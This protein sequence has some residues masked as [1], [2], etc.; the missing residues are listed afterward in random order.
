MHQSG[1][2]VDK[3]LNDAFN[4]ANANPEIG[5]VGI[6]IEDDKFKFVEQ[7]AGSF[8]AVQA[9]LVLRTP[10]YV[11]LRRDDKWLLVSFVPDNSNVRMKMLFASSASSLR[12]GLDTTKFLNPNFSM[13]DI[14]ECTETEYL[15]TISKDREI[16]MSFEEKD[17][18]ATSFEH[19]HSM[20]SNKTS[21]IADVPIKIADDAVAAMKNFGDG[22]GAFN[23]A[24]FTLASADETL[25]V[26]VTKDMTLADIAGIFPE[27]EPRFFL[28]NYA[29][30]NPT[31]N[32]SLNK[33]V[34][35]YYCPNFAP[36][37]MKM[38]YSSCK[39]HILKCLTELK[40][41]TPFNVEC[42][43]PKELSDE[44]LMK[45]LYP[46]KAVD[47]SFKK[48]KPR[49]KPKIAKFQA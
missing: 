6:T 15:R 36:P 21:V 8:D 4:D 16:V 11:C 33:L 41:D 31:D 7:G 23:C 29:H 24:E 25:N 27:R 18:L 38:M 37:K 49:S 48:P 30:T 20:G 1:I 32:S 47:T 43:D 44:H 26:G 17:K 19:A 42:D 5:W 22:G 45:D 10:L 39:S 40:L 12:N 14:E 3:E 28:H 9:K 46:P 34:F 35:V 13:T 2:A